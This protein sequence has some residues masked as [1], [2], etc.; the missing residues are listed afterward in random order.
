MGL[1]CRAWSAKL[2][3][4][5]LCSWTRP[6]QASMLEIALV[7]AGE[8]HALQST[9]PAGRTILSTLQPLCM[10]G[11]SEKPVYPELDSGKACRIL[12][13]F[14]AIVLQIQPI[15]KYTIARLSG[16]GN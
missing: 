2:Y 13:K 12:L 7:F 10:M 16:L 11:K 1:K 3:V 6:G 15:K 9:L 14:R 5:N 8:S 4:S